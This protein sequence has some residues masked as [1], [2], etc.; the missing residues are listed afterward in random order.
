MPTSF[1]GQME[2]KDVHCPVR[3]TLQDTINARGDGN[4]ARKFISLSLKEETNP[5]LGEDTHREQAGSID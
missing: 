5:Y 1:F 3:T 2:V 4:T